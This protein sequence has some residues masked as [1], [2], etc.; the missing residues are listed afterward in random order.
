MAPLTAALLL[1][2]LSSFAPLSASET[3]AVAEPIHQLRIYEIFEHNKT[4]FHARFRDHAV[5]I[6]KGYDFEIV[7]MWEA[8]SAERTEFVYILQWPDSATM[9]DRWT[10]FLADTAWSAI[11][12]RSAARHGQLVGRIESRVLRTTDYS[13]RLRLR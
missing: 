12:V 7:S 13:P 5:R 8:R 2:T 3:R 1:V 10:R 4:A 6:M 11:K 9:T